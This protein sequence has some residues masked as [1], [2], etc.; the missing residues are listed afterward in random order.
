DPPAR[1]PARPSGGRARPGG[2]RP[3]DDAALRV[4]GGRCL[5]GYSTLGNGRGCKAW[6]RRFE[7]RGP[8]TVVVR[9]HDLDRPPAAEQNLVE[10][11]IDVRRRAGHLLENTSRVSA[12]G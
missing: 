11:S 2:K 1:A 9:N 12:P 4:G 8:G 5:V 7:T 10:V 3:S 6:P